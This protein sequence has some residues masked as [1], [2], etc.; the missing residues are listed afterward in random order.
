MKYLI[1]TM[2]NSFIFIKYDTPQYNKKG[3]MS[4]YPKALRRIRVAGGANR[5]NMRGFGEQ[6][7]DNEGIP[8]WTP[9]GTSSP[10][11]ESD[12]AWLM[13]DEQFRLFVQGGHIKIVDQDY[14]G[15]HKELRKQTSDMSARDMHALLL[16]DDP[17][18][19]MASIKSNDDS[20]DTNLAGASDSDL[21]DFLGD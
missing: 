1:S 13:K 11:Q 5:P 3:E 6:T 14:S 15:N 9:S 19:K 2:T 17:R 18:L 10:V 20:F 7:T 8:M 16:P 4:G 21:S 12:L